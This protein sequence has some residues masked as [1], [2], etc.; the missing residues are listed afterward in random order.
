MTKKPST[1]P[2][3]TKATKLPAKTTPSARAES[4]KTRLIKM[5]HKDDGST[6][7]TISAALGWQPHTTRAA[8][9]GLRK[10][11]HKVETAKPADGSSG[12]IYRIPLKPDARAKTGND[13]EARQ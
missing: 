4:K 7:T 8:I 5:L 9:T 12:L 6:I 1:N 3:T 13:A 2:E 11:G 10:T